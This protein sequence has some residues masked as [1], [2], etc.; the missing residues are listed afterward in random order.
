MAAGALRSKSIGR[1]AASELGDRRM[2]WSAFRVGT[3]GY[4]A[5]A[6]SLS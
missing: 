4:G 5:S 1:K 6:S 3:N 2:L